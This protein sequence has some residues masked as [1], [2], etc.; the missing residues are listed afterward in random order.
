[1]KGDNPAT[2]YPALGRETPGFDQL[3]HL[4]VAQGALQLE[5]GV[6]PGLERMRGS[7][8]RFST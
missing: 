7:G 1:L 3:C 2:D 6:E 8:L 4:P 5:D